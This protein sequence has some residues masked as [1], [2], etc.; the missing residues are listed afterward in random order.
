M[1]KC[2]VAIAQNG[3]MISRKWQNK[4][5]GGKGVVLQS[6]YLIAFVKI[7]CKFNCWR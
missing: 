2:H 6:K 5:V 3:K 4:G 1:Q 7:K